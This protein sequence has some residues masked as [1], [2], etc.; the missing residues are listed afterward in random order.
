MIA[1]GAYV[2]STALAFLGRGEEAVAVAET[3]LRSHRLAAGL[4]VSPEA[5]LVGAVLG[6]AAGGRLTSA[7]A[8]AASAQQAVL[9]AGELE[10]LA[11]HQY[12]AGR[13]LTE[14]GQL[15]RASRQFA[16]AAAIN[17]ELKELG[18]LRWC[19]AGIAMAEAMSGHADRAEVAAA[20]MDGLP[21]AMALYEP[22]MIERSR[23]WVRVAAGEVSAAREILAAAA[24]RAAAMSLRV[25]EATL[26]HDL[27]RLGKPGQ[28]AQRLAELADQVDGALVPAFARH[29]ASLAGGAAAAELD[30]V[31]QDF[32]S[33]AALLYAAEAY[34]A[35]A[36]GYRSQGL[37]RR[38]SAAARKVD[39]LVAACGN[40]RTPA[41][42][43]AS[44]RPMAGQLTPREREVA[45][46][47]AAGA[48][49][50]ESAERLVL[51]VRTVDNHLQSAYGKLGVTS[52][53]ELAGVLRR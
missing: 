24:D 7:E 14:Q 50:R 9:A 5:Q 1:R 15:A 11:V 52:R 29:A 34:L 49:R 3:G 27:A 43:L 4:R 31:A 42:D 2:S 10:G 46:M 48:S 25:A 37:M 22:D 32:E 40:V 53:E 13:A 6:Y 26:L 41:L 21:V 38:A 35:A 39:E 47:A 33:M 23:A 36:D 51:S 19:L 16:D 8:T 44:A 30:A 18:A 45:A 28:V 12:L 20:E 17:R